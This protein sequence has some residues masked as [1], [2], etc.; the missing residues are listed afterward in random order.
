MALCSANSIRSKL[1]DNQKDEA[2]EVVFRKHGAVARDSKGRVFARAVR[3]GG[4]YVADLQ[5]KNPRHS[6]FA[7]RD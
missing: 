1:L 7:R 2:S 5:L 4:L 6:G 3:R